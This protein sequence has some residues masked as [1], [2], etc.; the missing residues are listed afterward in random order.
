MSGTEL[1]IVIAPADCPEP[2]DAAPV[3]AAACGEPDC[4]RPV[5]DHV[6]CARHKVWARDNGGRRVGCPGVCPPVAA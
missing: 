5:C 4:G 6:W 1:R 3:P 2:F